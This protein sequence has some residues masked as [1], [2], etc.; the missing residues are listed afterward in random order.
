MIEYIEGAKAIASLIPKVKDMFSKKNRTK[1]EMWGNWEAFENALGDDYNDICALMLACNKPDEK[2]GYTAYKKKGIRFYIVGEIGYT[3][4]IKE[5]IQFYIYFLKNRK[6][7]SIYNRIKLAYKKSKRWITKWRI[8]YE[9]DKY[10]KRRSVCNKCI[11]KRFEEGKIDI[12]YLYMY[13][14]N[15]ELK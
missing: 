2:F 6:D 1:V 10:F 5:Y 8:S 11:Q 3:K 15:K 12:V 13:N 14:T 4:L 7:L 9:I